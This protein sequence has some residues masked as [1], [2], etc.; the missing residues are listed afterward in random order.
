MPYFKDKAG[1]IHFLQDAGFAHLLPSGSKAITDAEAATLL[2]PTVA[3]LKAA[4]SLMMRNA[5]EAACLLPVS[6]GG[7]DWNGGFDS[8]LKLDAAKRLTESA[9]RTTVVFFDID[10]VGHVLT[11][12]E[13]LAVVQAVGADFQTKLARKQARLVSIEQAA[14]EAAVQAIVW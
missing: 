5:Y 1:A 6:A 11:I 9:G 7:H 4:Q 10:N 12:A 8:A 2:K 3:Q 13:A 14:D